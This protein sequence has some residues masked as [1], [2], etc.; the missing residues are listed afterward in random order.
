MSPETRFGMSS[1]F[2]DDLGQFTTR[3]Q[4]K[5]INRLRRF[6]QHV[7]E[8]MSRQILRNV[9]KLKGLRGEQC[10]SLGRFSTQEI[11]ALSEDVRLVFVDVDRTPTAYWVVAFRKGSD[12]DY[13][14]AC[15]QARAMWD[16]PPERRP[17]LRA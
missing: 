11:R 17:K 15:Q 2:E 14:R 1:T 10:K 12:R 8:G 9:Y 16:T 13:D 5:C 4:I 7:R 6:E 3:D